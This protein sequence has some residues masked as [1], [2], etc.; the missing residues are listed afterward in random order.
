MCWFTLKWLQEQELNRS[1]PSSRSPTWVQGLISKFNN[2]HPLIKECLQYVKNA[3]NHYF[4]ER[5]AQWK[6]WWKLRKREKIFHSF[7]H[8]QTF[9]TAMAGPG[10]NQKHG[11]QCRAPTW[12][13]GTQLFL[14]SF[15]TSQSVCELEAG[16]ESRTETPAQGL[17]YG[18][19]ATQITSQP[20]YQS[21]S[22]S[23]FFLT[24]PANYL[25]C[26]KHCFM[27]QKYTAVNEID[28]LLAIRKNVIS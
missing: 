5:Q 2:L 12:M 4:F 27:Q 3:S 13:T 24:Q 28:K 19:W 26:A 15:A 14:S 6:R 1:E 23:L 25:F 7:V 22:P 17:Q 8:S 11:T 16:I 20:L 21:L 18:M 10:P 9:T